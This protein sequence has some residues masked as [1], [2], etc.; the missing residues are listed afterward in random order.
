MPEYAFL[1]QTCT[2]PE[3]NETSSEAR[4]HVIAQTLIKITDGLQSSL[5]SFDAGGWRVLSHDLLESG[6]SLI[7]S[8]LICR[9]E[10]KRSS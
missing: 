7:V 2:M 1:V 4:S 10:R 8:F 5:Q 9:E 6:N 3:S